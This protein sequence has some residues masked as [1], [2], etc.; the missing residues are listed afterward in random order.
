MAFS[1]QALQLLGVRGSNFFLQVGEGRC[2]GLRTP[3]SSL[4]S[5]SCLLL[6]AVASQ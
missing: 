4:I 3:S 1:A 5:A 6:R 2:G